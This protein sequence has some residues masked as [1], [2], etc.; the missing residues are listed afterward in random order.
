MK[1]SNGE[2]YRKWLHSTPNNGLI[3]FRVL[4]NEERVLLTSPQALREVLVTKAYVFQKL[5]KP[6]SLF[7]AL[8][9]NGLLAAEGDVHHEQRK[10][11]APAFSFRHIKDLYPVFCRSL[12]FLMVVQ[13][14]TI[15]HRVKSS[16]ERSSYFC[17]STVS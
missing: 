14:L 13:I 6:Q 10:A 15:Y 7:R 2:P 3:R 5:E 12:S 11:I 9:G 1:T 4:L 16:R 8:L 17:G